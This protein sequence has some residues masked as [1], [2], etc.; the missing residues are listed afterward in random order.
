MDLLT[1]V[2]KALV[3]EYR[4]RRMARFAAWVMA[5]GIALWVAG[6]LARSSGGAPG[7][8]WFL[9]WILF[10]GVAGYYAVRLVRFIRH[11]VLWRLRRRLIVAY[12]FIAVVPILLILLLVG[13]GVF[14]INGQFAAFL[15]TLK[16]REHVDELRQL[17]RVVGHEAHQS[18]QPNP[19]VLLDRLQQFYF[20][21]LREHAESYP[22]LEVTARVGSR[23]KNLRAS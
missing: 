7:P 14:I 19:T 10:L 22:G 2:L 15:V 6:R 1:I 3:D 23:A 18:R 11:R 8:L 16:I 21:E 5:Y 9:F 13:L 4:T 12:L 20:N 17:N